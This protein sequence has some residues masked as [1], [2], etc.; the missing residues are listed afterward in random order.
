MQQM[1]LVM[2][3]QMHMQ[4]Q[5][6]GLPPG[7]SGLPMHLLQQQQQMQALQVRHTACVHPCSVK[8]LSVF[9]GR[10]HVLLC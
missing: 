4:Q 2:Q 3:K 9:W 6:G 1:A 8:N 5:Q 10:H 7:S